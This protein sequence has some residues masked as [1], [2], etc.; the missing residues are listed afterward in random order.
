MKNFFNK[1]K[2]A[3]SDFADSFKKG[4]DKK[5]RRRN[6]IVVLILAVL[7]AAIPTTI[8]LSQPS[9][10]TVSFEVTAGS[11]PTLSAVKV[12]DKI[13]APTAPTRAGYDF[14]GWYE[15]AG[16]AG[17]A[18]SFPYAVKKDTT[19]H[20]K[21]TELFTVTFNPNAEESE[22]GVEAATYKVRDDGTVARPADPTRSGYDFGGWY[23]DGEC[24]AAVEFPYTVTQD[25]A[26]YAKWTPIEEP[27]EE[28]AFSVTYAVNGGA[29]IPTENVSEGAAVQEPTAPTRTGYA[30]DGWFITE[31]FAGNAVEFPYT[32]NVD[33]TFYAKWTPTYTVRYIVSGGAPIIPNTTFRAGTVINAPAAPTKSNNEFDGWYLTKELDGSVV[34]FPY[35]V[36]ANTVFYAK[37]TPTYTVSYVVNGGTPS[38]IASATVRAGTQLLTP[39]ELTRS[40]YAFDGWFTNEG[41][42]GTQE[43]FP[44]TVN[45]NT[46]FYAKW[47]PTYT[48]SYVVNGGTPSSI[49]SATVRAGTQLLTPTELT[50]SNYAFDGWFTTSDFSGTQETFPY[51]VNANTTFY[52]KW[53]PTYTVGYVVNGGTP[54]ISSV[55]VRA[56][57]QLPTPTE[58][59]RSNYAFDGWFTNEG[60]TGTQ[61]TFPYTVNAN[62]TFYVKW[63]PTYTVDFELNEGAGESGVFERKTV[64]DGTSVTPATPTRSG[65]EF[66]GWFTNSGLTGTKESFPYTVNADVIFYASWTVLH[67]VAFNLNGGISETIST[68]VCRGSGNAEFPANPTR[69]GYVFAGWYETVGLTGLPVLF[70]W[71]RGGSTPTSVTLYA[72]WISD[73]ELSTNRTSYYSSVMKN[74]IFNADLKVTDIAMLGAHDAFTH[75]ITSTSAWNTLDDNYSKWSSYFAL[76][77][78]STIKGVSSKFSKAQ[79]SGAYDLAAYGVRFYDGRI[80]YQNSTWYTAHGLISDTLE[81]YIVDMIK[82]LSENPREF[83]VFDAQAIFVGT[84]NHAALL[85]HIANIA[86]NG[87]TLFDFVY[88]DTTAKSLSELTY[89]DV[90]KNGG[91][92]I[93]TFNSLPSGITYGNKAYSRSAVYSDTWANTDNT[94]I[95][96]NTI[97]INYAGFVNGTRSAI[98]QFIVNQAQLTPQMENI[99][100]VLALVSGGKTLIS[101]ANDSNA[102]VIADANFTN[103]LSY[104]PIIWVDNADEETFNKQVIP[105]IHTV[106]LAL[107]FQGKAK[108]IED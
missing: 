85:Q 63:T 73:S 49:A 97:N 99:S 7:I 91:G 95:L 61:E 6:I 93:M 78:E 11:A 89:G 33:T 94:A 87:K 75:N 42:T 48:V 108:I 59:T 13:D 10:A 64:R 90:T 44:Y 62:T 88:Y 29:S 101:M 82:F 98:G 31:D 17:T 1:V 8:I 26:F 36:N 60:L 70:P 106:N 68:Q 80:T 102:A 16:F 69:S 19:L 92:V 58:L 3:A 103:W 105:I 84:S 45:A 86:Y 18:V 25:I 66:S 107:N 2:R 65:Y 24:T 37:W 72:K 79:S 4:G 51:T 46:T 56:G 30:F 43:T 22:E 9:K 39:T 81:S 32:V 40:N 5:E 38:S 77:G 100:Q 28:T 47:T 27:I 41:L 71:A 12:G 83:L 35:T 67:S 55:T 54:S 53:T 20:A 21:W 96:I 15:D 14:D 76:V 104:M 74:S 52:A 57:T 23:F 34:T 50:R